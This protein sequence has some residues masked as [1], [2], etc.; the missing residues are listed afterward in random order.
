MTPVYHNMHSF[1][2]GFLTRHG[3]F[4]VN[5]DAQ[6]KRSINSIKLSPKKRENASR[7][8][9]LMLF[10]RPDKMRRSIPV[11]MPVAAASA[12]GVKPR[13]SRSRCSAA[14][15][16]SYV[17]IVLLL[18]LVKEF[19]HYHL[20]QLF[21][22]VSERALQRTRLLLRRRHQFERHEVANLVVKCHD[23]REI[24]VL[25]RQDLRAHEAASMRF[26]V[27]PFDCRQRA[28]THRER[29]A[30]RRQFFVSAAFL[31]PL[32]EINWS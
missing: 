9:V 23:D 7:F 22:A 2:N 6:L 1:R 16:F 21:R 15:A 19:G 18:C 20:K 5:S 32:P 8:L 11:S 30:I 3:E 13:P 12:A 10:C 24:T 25:S 29:D 4:S 14:P 28:L 26:A 31:R 17:R 27:K